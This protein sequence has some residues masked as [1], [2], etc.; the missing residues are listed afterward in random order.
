MKKTMI[1]MA[2]ATLTAGA[3]LNA[4]CS[5][6][7]CSK[8]QAAAVAA[9]TTEA[10]ATTLTADEMAF[11]AKLNDANRHTFSDKLSAEQRS[12][13]MVA[14]KNGA[15][16]DEAVQRMLAAKEMKEA[17]SVANA[18]KATAETTAK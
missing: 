7:A 1:I 11:S 14:A 9:P 17:P 3:T 6:S 13:V 8:N 5:G 18:E 2:L 15:N 12:A 10:V 16:E 4:Q